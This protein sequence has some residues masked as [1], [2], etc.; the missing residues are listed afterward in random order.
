M[1][2]RG[3][4]RFRT[5]KEGINQSELSPEVQPVHLAA[6]SVIELSV[7]AAATIQ[8]EAEQLVPNV[9]GMHLSHTYSWASGERSSA[10]AS[11]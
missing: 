11:R 7:S 4:Q 5:D 2:I 6:L 10:F 3:D 9:R 1:W 8:W